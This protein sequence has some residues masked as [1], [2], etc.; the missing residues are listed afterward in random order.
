M[1]LVRSSFPKRTTSQKSRDPRIRPRA[2]D[3]LVNQLNS[4][5]LLDSSDPESRSSV[6]KPAP[7]P[8]K[9]GKRSQWHSTPVAHE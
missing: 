8:T 9:A 5:N 6:S 2:M 3:S 4:W 1:S 7:T